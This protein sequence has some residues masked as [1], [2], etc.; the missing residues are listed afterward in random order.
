MALAIH[1]SAWKTCLVT[2]YFMVNAQGHDDE[3]IANGILWLQQYAEQAGSAA[4]VVVPSLRQVE[5]LASKLGVGEAVLKKQRRFRLG[6]VDVGVMIKKDLTYASFEGPMLGLWVDDQLLPK[7]EAMRPAAICAIP[8]LHKDIEKWKAARAPHDLRTG[9]QASEPRISNRVVEA[10]L[11]NL[12]SSVNL[13]TGLGHP[14]DKDHAVGIFRALVAARETFDTD[15]IRAWAAANG[16][17]ADDADELAD[18][19]GRLA[20]G[21]KVMTKGWSLPGD[22]V[23]RWRAEVGADA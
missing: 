21:R 12:T 9:H 20:E 4:A 3:A 2:D 8:W 14:S 19:A 10:A 13:S 6:S 1:L 11:S 22:A 16:W 23:D 7:M 15:E 18:L 5:S 17:D